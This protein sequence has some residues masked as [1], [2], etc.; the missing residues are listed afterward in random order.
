[1]HPAANGRRSQPL[2]RRGH[3]SLFAFKVIKARS[4][5]KKKRKETAH[6]GE[7]ASRPTPAP[8]SR[9]EEQATLRSYAEERV[10]AP[11]G[12]PHMRRARKGCSEEK[13]VP[14]GHAR[15]WFFGEGDLLL[16][17]GRRPAPSSSS[18]GPERAR[19]DA[20]VV[21]S[22]RRPD[23]ERRPGQGLVVS[24]ATEWARFN[25]CFC[26]RRSCSPVSGEASPMHLTQVEGAGVGGGRGMAGRFSVDEPS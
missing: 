19:P 15:T 23:G 12:A 14:Q 11:D 24:L 2:P 6:P 10:R 16:L 5:G 9:L 22:G 18:W 25:N 17:R 4:V 26:R 21:F 3:P 13:P 20:R 1:M 8:S 7:P